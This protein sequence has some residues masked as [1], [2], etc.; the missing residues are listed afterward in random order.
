[1]VGKCFNLTECK[2][3]EISGISNLWANFRNN[4]PEINVFHL[5][6]KQDFRN[7]RQM[8]SARM[9]HN[10]YLLISLLFDNLFQ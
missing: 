1:M 10:I 9:C 3:F 5:I 2:N 6:F 4:I 8:E 7:F